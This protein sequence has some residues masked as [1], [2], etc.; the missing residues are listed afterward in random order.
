MRNR[1][2]RSASLVALL[3]LSVATGNAVTTTT[4][5]QTTAT[6]ISSCSVSAGNLAFGNYDALSALPTNATSSVTVQCTLQSPY[7][8]GLNAGTGTGATVA[9]RKMTKGV[10]TLNF[11]L[12][13]DA[14]HLVLWGDT[15]ADLVSG[16]GTGAAVVI[17]VY[18][19]VPAAQ[20][21]P[22]GAYADTVTV[23]V[24]Y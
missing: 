15:G 20:N 24:N 14:S 12:Y 4:T 23:T 5:F 18:G 1:L 8:L 10:D 17:T 7:S 11:A 6:V 2:A 19:Q 9:V 16:T 13:K 21:V 22:T 3:A